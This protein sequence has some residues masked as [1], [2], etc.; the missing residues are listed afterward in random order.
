VVSPA[1]PHC[2]LARHQC[3]ACRTLSDCTGADR[4]SPAGECVQGCNVGA[5]ELCPSGKQCCQEL[6]IDTN[7]DPLNCGGCGTSCSLANGTP[8]C[9]GFCSWTCASGYAH[10]TSGN[11]GCE[12]NVRSD[13]AHCGACSTSCSSLVLNAT[14]LTCTAGACG[15]TS[16]APGFADCDG[17]HAN[18]CECACGGHGQACC[19]GGVC[20]FPGGTCNGGNKCI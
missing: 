18:G 20:N 7:A 9:S 4:C 6:C 15:Y 8:A 11:T 19:P 2:D 16:C 10:C 5:G 14:G 1:A 13:P 17:N 3:V 12:T